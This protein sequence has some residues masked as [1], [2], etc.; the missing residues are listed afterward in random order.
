MI[1]NSTIPCFFCI[2]AQVVKVFWAAWICHRV[3]PQSGAALYTSLPFAAGSMG[4]PAHFSQAH[5]IRSTRARVVALTFTLVDRTDIRRKYEYC[6][7]QEQLGTAYRPQ[8]FSEKV[9]LKFLF[10]HQ[11]LKT[12]NILVSEHVCKH[13]CWLNFIYHLFLFFS[14]QCIL[15]L[16]YYSEFKFCH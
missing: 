13:P 7:H 15:G 1:R 3:V 5:I 2:G 9:C 16:F 14:H 8:G 10:C 12:S 11:S 6:L 4:A